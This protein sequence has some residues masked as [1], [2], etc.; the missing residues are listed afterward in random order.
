[1]LHERAANGDCFAVAA[2]AAA[3]TA[4]ATANTSTSTADDSTHRTAA[5]V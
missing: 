2:A 3:A 5:V 1:V 4:T